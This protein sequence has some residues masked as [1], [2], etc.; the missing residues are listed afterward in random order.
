MQG[1][2]GM[3]MGLDFSTMMT[4]KRVTAWIIRVLVRPAAPGGPVLRRQCAQCRPFRAATGIP[5]HQAWLRRAWRFA[6]PGSLSAAARRG[7]ALRLGPQGPA[8]EPQVP[9]SRASG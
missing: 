4:V 7:R 8:C 2:Q 5:A 9:L 3:K 1:Q 6:P